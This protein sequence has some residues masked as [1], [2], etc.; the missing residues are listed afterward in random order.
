MN[1]LFSVDKLQGRN[2]SVKPEVNL[3]DHTEIMKAA[4]SGNHS[5]LRWVSSS[6]IDT[7]GTS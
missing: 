3:A 1:N 4:A 2:K 5:R 7:R 6:I